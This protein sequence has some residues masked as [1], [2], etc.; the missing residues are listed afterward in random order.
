MV[1]RSRSRSRTSRHS[2]QHSKR[3]SRKSIVRSPVRFPLVHQ[4]TSKPSTNQLRNRDF[5]REKSVQNV[6]KKMAA[7]SSGS[8]KRTET[9]VYST[10]SNDPKQSLEKKVKIEGEYE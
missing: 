4:S 7:D 3:S 8:H 9:K 10:G 1:R 6:T 2:E 5:S